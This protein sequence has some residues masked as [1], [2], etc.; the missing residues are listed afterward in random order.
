MPT[1]EEAFKQLGLSYHTVYS[2]IQREKARRAQVR[3]SKT[4]SR[5]Q[6]SRYRIN[7]RD[8]EYI[9]MGEFGF[10]V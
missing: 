6:H 2:A 1:V 3:V 7:R 8:A 5:T 9:Q 10:L 4:G